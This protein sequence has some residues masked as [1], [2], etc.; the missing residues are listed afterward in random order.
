MAKRSACHCVDRRVAR[1]CLERLR[2]EPRCHWKWFSRDAE[3]AADVWLVAKRVLDAAGIVILREF[4]IKDRP[5]HEVEKTTRLGRGQFFHAVYRTESAL[6]RALM[7]SPMF[8]PRKYFSGL[9]EGPI[10]ERSTGG[11]HGWRIPPK[12]VSHPERA[13]W[14]LRAA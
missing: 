9:Q 12:P 6:G 10:A 14:R 1:Q 3:Y 2:H 7:D 11:K 8:P 5:W 4:L 13:G